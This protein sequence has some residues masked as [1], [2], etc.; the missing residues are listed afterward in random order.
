MAVFRYAPIYGR[1]P[2]LMIEDSD[3]V[4]DFFKASGTPFVCHRRDIVHFGSQPNVYWIE[5]GLVASSAT[6]DVDRHALDR[7]LFAPHALGKRAR[8]RSRASRHD[9]DGHSRH[10]RVRIRRPA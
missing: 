6:T 3:E 9:L 2:W 1:N 5:S 4:A 10:G 8:H 7:A